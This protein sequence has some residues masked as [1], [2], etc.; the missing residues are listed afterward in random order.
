MKQRIN[1]YIFNITFI[2]CLIDLVLVFFFYYPTIFYFVKSFD[3][4]TPFK[5]I[6]MPVCYSLGEIFELISLLGLNHHFEASNTLYSNISSLRSNPVGD[7]LVLIT[8]FLFKKNPVLYHL[9]SLCLHLINTALVFFILNNV[10]LTLFKTKKI[11]ILLTT[12]LLTLLWAL[13]PVNIEP[14]L[15]LTNYNAL[16]GYTLCLF[17][18]FFYISNIHENITFLKSLILFVTYTLALYITEYNFMLPFILFAYTL[19]IKP[20]K[21]SFRATLP[22]FISLIIFIFSFLFSNT[23]INLEVSSIT[24]TLERIFWLSPQLIIHLTKLLIFPIELSVDQ[25]SFVKIADS[26][27]D[28][29]A[30]VCIGIII[31]F[32]I[33]SFKSKNFAMFFLSLIPFSHIIAPVYNLA[34]ER[35]LYFPSFIFFFGISHLVFFILSKYQNKKIIVL[36]TFFC[37]TSVLT[38]YSYRAYTRKLDWK[39]SF[40]LYKSAIDSTNSP[41][42][43]AFRYKLLAPQE[44]IFS[45]FPHKE[46]DP[47]YQKLAIKNL[48]LGIN[49]L[50]ED[51]KKYQSTIPQI[52]KYYGLDPN[53]LLAK[54]GYLLAHSN[55]TMYGDPKKALKIIEPYVKDLSILDSAS[56]AFYASLLFY[57]KNLEEAEKILRYAYNKQPY[58][59]R[60]TFPLCQL[61]YIRTG[62]LNEVEKLSL[63]AFGY[64]PYDTYTLLFLIK[65]YKL[66]GNTEKFAFYSYI[67]GIRHHSIEFLQNAENLYI[68]LNNKDMAIKARKRIFLLEKKLKRFV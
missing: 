32:I 29:Y 17:V 44:K 23:R 25:T 4:I 28:P 46:V 19:A 67:Y 2:F 30:I 3:E 38:T 52:I 51:K 7:F 27:F 14:V 22:I 13:H 49:K 53:T 40:T 63:R 6:H 12:S 42:Y 24:A 64:F 68:S 26:L 39:D 54:A 20:Q 50:E 66:K 15:L 41:L 33:L 58:L 18:T 8:Q 43:K 57:D 16:L 21:K 36:L 45:K 10:S 37:L 65:L 11:V 48:E 55:Y 1:F 47:K 34:S 9:Y 35:Y 60:I 62:D 56:L 31:L 5:E 59:T 61:I